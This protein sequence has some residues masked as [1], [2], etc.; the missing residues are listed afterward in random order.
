MAAIQLNDH[1]LVTLTM[2]VGERKRYTKMVL[3]E[4]PYN[5]VS[6]FSKC[7][8]MTDRLLEAVKPVGSRDRSNIKFTVYIKEKSA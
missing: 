4:K 6:D 1:E 3:V 7:K 8:V 5:Y 2:K